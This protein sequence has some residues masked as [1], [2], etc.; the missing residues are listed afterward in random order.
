MNCYRD[1]IALRKHE[2]SSLRSI[3]RKYSTAMFS[4]FLNQSGTKLLIT[5]NKEISLN[6][7]PID[8]V[9]RLSKLTD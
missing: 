3:T 2:N 6:N 7:L 9:T 5:P 4:Y 8:L 1:I